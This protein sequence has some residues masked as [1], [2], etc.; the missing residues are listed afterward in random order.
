MSR[1]MSHMNFKSN[2][3]KSKL[4]IFSQI[5]PLKP[6]PISVNQNS[7]HPVAWVKKKIEAFLTPLFPHT[8]SNT[9]LLIL[10]FKYCLESHYFSLH[11][12]Y[13]SPR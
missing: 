6:L 7:I 11:L 12:E 3:S 2:T 10:P 1:W 13:L 8:Q 5:P 9:V 4:Y